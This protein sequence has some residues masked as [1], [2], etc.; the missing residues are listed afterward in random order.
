MAALARELARRHEVTVLT[1]RAFDL[2]AESDDA[3]VRVVRTPVFFRRQMAV[4][5]MP[6]LLA[7]LPMAVLRGLA[8]GRGRFDLVN[9]HF[10]VPSGPAGHLLA[11]LNGAP[12]VLSLH[13]GDLYDPSKRISPHRHAWLRTPIRRLLKTADVLIGQSRNTALHVKDIYR[14]DRNVDL[15]PLGIERPVSIGP[16]S[17]AEFGLPSDAF[18]MTTVGRIVPR[19]ATTQLIQALK[20][21]ALPQA[22]LLIIGEG[23]DTATVRRAASEAGVAQRVHFLGALDEQEKY[24]V[25]AM[26]DVFV[27]SSQHEGFGLVFLEAMAMG[28]PIVCYD[29]GGQTDFLSTP[30]TGYVISLNDLDAFTR[31]LVDL[32]SDP[33]QRAD[34][35][36][37]N[38]KRIEQYFIDTCAA[39]YEHIFLEAQERHWRRIADQRRTA[40]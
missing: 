33:Q 10:V 18:V 24:R 37:R 14:V 35:S 28:L 23:P 30:D 5:N 29:H 19:K 34:M 27:S 21:S 36:A 20:R 4:A 11:R 2:P 9:T 25:L 16:A 32:S 12:H 15:I 22:H 3:G 31:A 7:F 6:S 40:T 39:R 8:L 1:S 17:R 26:S 13:G 38:R